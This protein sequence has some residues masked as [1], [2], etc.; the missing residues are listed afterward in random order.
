MTDDTSTAGPAHSAFRILAALADLGEATATAIAEHTRLGYSTVTPKLR[1][2]ENSGHAERYRSDSNQTLWR[3]TATGRATTTPTDA[4][5]AAPDT[6]A[7]PEDDATTAG[8]DAA[9]PTGDP[10]AP[11]AD[12]PVDEAPTAAHTEPLSGNEAADTGSTEDQGTHQHVDVATSDGAENDA[13]SAHDSPD[14]AA[15]TDPASTHAG[16][17]AAVTGP[18]A[19][20]TSAAPPSHPAPGTGTTT[21]EATAPADDPGKDTGNAAT[22]ERRAS[23]LLRASVLKVLQTRPGQGY[24][25]SEL[26]NLINEANSG[27]GA[28]KASAGAV[29]NAAHKLVEKGHALLLVEH[30]A[31]FSSTEAV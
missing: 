16:P 29:A 8:P 28:S 4:P 7:A 1:A 27:T 14:N 23:G 6:A 21:A 30:P 24:K 22:G 31:T 20:A 5:A 19:P 9:A 2:W 13:G 11:L 3:L 15:L 26:C 17:E 25:V 12:E 10:G 18:D